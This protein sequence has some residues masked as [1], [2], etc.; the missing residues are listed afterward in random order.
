MISMYRNTKENSHGNQK[1]SLDLS[2]PILMGLPI[3]FL[4]FW[5]SPETGK[6]EIVDGSQRLRTLQEFVLGNLK[7]TELEEL[8]RLDGFEY[9]DLPESRQRKIKNK[10][11]RGIILNEHTNEQ[12]RFDLFNRIN[13]SSKAANKAEVRR[14]ALGGPFQDLVIKLADLPEFI[15]VAPLSKK[16]TD[17]RVREEL[18]TRF[19]AYGDGLESYRDRVSK[20]TYE[21]TKKTNTLFTEKKQLINEYED[22]FITMISFVKKHF[23]WGFKRTEKGTFTPMSRFESIAIGSH[24]ALTKDPNLTTKSLNIKKWHNGKE[25]KQITNADGANVRKKLIRRIEYVQDRLLGVTL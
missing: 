17:E 6:L 13:T 20:F 14:G 22:R 24:K 8:T 23:P 18:V 3:P 5:E 7:I 25:F 15:E 12:S 19:F 11:I 16:A 1:E 21:Y 4:L 10:S 2:N 9:L